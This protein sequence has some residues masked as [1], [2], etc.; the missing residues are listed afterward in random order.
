[1]TRTNIPNYYNIE[2]ITQSSNI[3]VLQNTESSLDK[4]FKQK[5][6]TVDDIY[7]IHDLLV[8]YKRLA[9]TEYKI[10]KE[11]NTIV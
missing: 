5:S 4:Y 10:K 7:K 3:E 6:F 1:M 2:K 11:E 8:K 9:N